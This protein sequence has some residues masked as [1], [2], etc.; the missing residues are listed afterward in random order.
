MKKLCLVFI[1]LLIPTLT[2]ANGV[3]WE[4]LVA[5]DSGTTQFTSVPDAVNSA[6]IFHTV[7]DDVRFGHGKATLSNSTSPYM[8][9]GD[10]F[11]FKSRHEVTSFRMTADSAGSGASIFIIGYSY[12]EDVR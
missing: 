7:G 3:V 10:R 11:V 6:V 12:L 2:F 8:E 5:V 9:V 1:I 4:Q